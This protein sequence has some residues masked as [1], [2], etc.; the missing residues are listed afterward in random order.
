[1]I[2][3]AVVYCCCVLLLCTD[4]FFDFFSPSGKYGDQVGLT[5]LG[6]CKE[7][8]EGR[9][10]DSVIKKCKGMLVGW[11]VCLLVG[12]LVVGCLSSSSLIH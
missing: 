6:S 12:L 11:L 4:C 1:M 5:S 9:Y 7:C 3:V 2:D 10:L 8:S